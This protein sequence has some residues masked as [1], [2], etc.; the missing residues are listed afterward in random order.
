MKGT[1][2][3]VSLARIISLLLLVLT[4]AMGFAM[5]VP[6]FAAFFEGRTNLP[7]FNPAARQIL[8]GL[9][10]GVYPLLMAIGAPILGWLS[11]MFGRKRVLLGCCIGVAL[12]FLLIALGIEYHQVAFI[13]AG[14]AVGGVTAASQAVAIAALTDLSPESKRSFHVNMALLCSSLGFVLGPGLAGLLSSLAIGALGRAS[15]PLLFVTLLALTSFALIFFALPM[16][17][18][19]GLSERHEGA[20][21]LRSLAKVLS[22]RPLRGLCAVYFI[23][24]LGWGAWFF[25]IPIVMVGALK[26]NSG[27]VSLFMAVVGIGFC[28]SYGVLMPV[29]LRRF[30]PVRI[31]KSTLLITLLLTVLSAFG[32]TRLLQWFLALPISLIGAAVYGALIVIFAGMTTPEDRGQVL[33][34]TASLNA[35]AFGAITVLGGFAEAF[36][37]RAGLVLAA[38]MLGVSFGLAL[39]WSSLPEVIGISSSGLSPKTSSIVP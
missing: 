20:D 33:A 14:R 27:E 34:L 1:S 39:A 11:D 36:S 38:I 3:Y 8:Y 29:L 19:N 31:M 37:I 28:L 16:E 7:G 26:A 18:V 22:K 4:D 12:G 5:V 10:V 9:A 15:T 21:M 25:F 35:L 13:L 30:P 23:E 32:E 6:L 24:Q 2:H 17:H